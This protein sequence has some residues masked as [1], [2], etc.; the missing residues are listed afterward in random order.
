MV[1][2]GGVV[3]AGCPNC[4]TT[5]NAGPIAVESGSP[6]NAPVMNAPGAPQ[7]QQ[8]APQ[9]QQAAPQGQAAPP[10]PQAPA[11]PEAPKA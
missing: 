3:N 1:Y 2:G 11:A 10:A 9:G 4:S 8:A 5:L 7:G 6:S